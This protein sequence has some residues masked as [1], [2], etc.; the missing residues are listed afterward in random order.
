M[1]SASWAATRFGSSHERSREHQAPHAKRSGGGEVIRM[2]RAWV[3]VCLFALLA[4]G[5]Q[6]ESARAS[7]DPA[8][9]IDGN[10]VAPAAEVLLSS[11]DTFGIQ[12]GFSNGS[13]STVQFTATMLENDFF[14]AEHTVLT[15]SVPAG[16]G[17]ASFPSFSTAGFPDGVDTITIRITSDAT[18]DTILGSCEFVL[19]I[20]DD[21]DGD[22][23]LDDWETTGL[24]TDGDGVADSWIPI[25]RICCSSSTTWQVRLQTGMTSAR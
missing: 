8:A 1:G 19:R 20:G 17:V 2:S 5:V 25:T 15:R 21:T 12:I 3:P 11:G 22:G 10:C 7:H 13:S 14:G 24:D 4:I 9:P 6:G 23:L 16:V 18:G